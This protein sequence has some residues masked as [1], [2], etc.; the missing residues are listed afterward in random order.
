MTYQAAGMSSDVWRCSLLLQSSGL[1]GSCK[2]PLTPRMVGK[3][4]NL[5]NLEKFIPHL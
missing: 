5:K 2:E 3:L 4:Y 1:L